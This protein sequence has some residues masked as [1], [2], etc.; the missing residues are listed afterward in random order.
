MLSLQSLGA[1][2]SVHIGTLL[3]GA[4]LPIA[5]TRWLGTEALGI[6]TVASSFGLLLLTVID[7]GYETRLPLLAAAA[8]THCN[9]ILAEAHSAKTRLWFVTMLC[10]G[11]AMFVHSAIVPIPVLRFVSFET[12]APLTLY[13]VWAVVRSR[14]MTYSAILR[15]LQQFHIVAQVENGATVVSYGAAMI[16]MAVAMQYTVTLDAIAER[17]VMVIILCIPILWLLIGEVGKS[18]AFQRFWRS[19]SSAHRTPCEAVQTKFPLS[20]EHSVFVM[21]QVI[22]LVQSRAGMYL[23]MISSGATE[24]GMFS[25]VMRFIIVLRLFPGALFQV[26]LPKFVQHREHRFLAKA[27]VFAGGVGCLGS[28]AVMYG[29]EWCI[30]IVY[31]VAFA[32]LTPLLQWASWLF[33]LQT[34]GQVL[35]S[36]LLAWQQE[37]FVHWSLFACVSC[38]AIAGY[39]MS[40]TTAWSAIIASL[41][42]EAGI[43]ILFLGKVVALGMQRNCA[44]H[45]KIV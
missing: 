30:R 9:L 16:A 7:W 15:G 26:L 23:L 19:L 43:V 28:V 3:A 21:M 32:H 20:W 6:F 25:A 37:S 34:I 11:L 45:E 8:P 14:T 39:S 44:M 24:L 41:V 13:A 31:G 2:L 5:M 36:Y 17:A 40:V 4:L 10:I 12:L 18:I 35:E 29:A 27:L 42:L 33:C 1:V 22:S 38:F